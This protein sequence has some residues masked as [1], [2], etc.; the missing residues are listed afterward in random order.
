MA[1]SVRRNNKQ[2]S[3]DGSAAK[4]AE[5]L[6]KKIDIR[7]HKPVRWILNYEKTE[8]E[9]DSVGHYDLGVNALKIRDFVSKE[10][11]KDYGK[12]VIKD[13]KDYLDEGQTKLYDAMKFC[14]QYT[15]EEVV[16]RSKTPMANG[17]YF[18]WSHHRALLSVKDEAQREAL[19]KQAF[20]QGWTSSQLSKEVWKLENPENRETGPNIK[21]PEN[22]DALLEQMEKPTV[23]WNK[24]E[25]QVWSQPDYSLSTKARKLSAAEMDEDKLDRVRK[26][27]EELDQIVVKA[28]KRSKDA[29]Q[30]I[31]WLE[32]QLRQ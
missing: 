6:L 13:L 1:K 11:G 20:A 10:G 21:K 15:R 25:D 14:K 12:S 5:D 9:H 18:K 7:L 30:T 28:K 24:Y 16:S 22:F 23:T 3:S 29:E 8:A 2:V 17:R 4:P 26:L 27:K 19:L 31:Q 32:K